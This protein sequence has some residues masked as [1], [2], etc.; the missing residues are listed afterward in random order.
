MALMTELAI[1]GSKFRNSLLS[2]A[3]ICTDL[4]PLDLQ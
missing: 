3:L 2:S 4:V 1:D